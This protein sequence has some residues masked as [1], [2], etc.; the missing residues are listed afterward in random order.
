M[1]HVLNFVH[2]ILVIK[3]FIYIYFL[4]KY[5]SSNLMKKPSIKTV[6]VILI[7]KAVEIK[8]FQVLVSPSQNKKY[9]GRI[10]QEETILLFFIEQ[11]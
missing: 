11:N 9:Y 4:Q 3:Y 6:P 7:I 10:Q 1:L 8:T 5:Y 2:R